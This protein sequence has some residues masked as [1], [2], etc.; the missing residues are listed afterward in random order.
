MEIQAHYARPYN[1][2]ERL[3]DW[4]APESAFF[5]R[6][7]VIPL[8]NHVCLTFSLSS[9]LGGILKVSADKW[10]GLVLIGFLSSS[11]GGLLSS[12]HKLLDGFHL[13]STALL[14]D[15]GHH[16]LEVL[17]GGGSLA[18]DEGILEGVMD[19]RLSNVENGFVIVEEVDFFNVGDALG[20]YT[21]MHD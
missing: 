10:W 17:G 20:G 7:W 12:G 8:R 2:V 14:H 1:V 3:M 9:F 6:A 4:R 11:L 19:Q 21:K 13:L 15:L 5:S 18:D 16:V